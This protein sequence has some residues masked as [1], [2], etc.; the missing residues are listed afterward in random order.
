MLPR[1]AQIDLSHIFLHSFN[2]KSDIINSYAVLATHI[3]NINMDKKCLP[4]LPP[5]INQF[6]INNL[7]ITIN[8]YLQ[9]FLAQ[10]I[11]PCLVLRKT[12]FHELIMI[13]HP[14]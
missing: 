3:L 5:P 9:R 13:N 7:N 10:Q 8:E 4:I 12:Y 6:Y 1:N 11:V 2:G 14:I